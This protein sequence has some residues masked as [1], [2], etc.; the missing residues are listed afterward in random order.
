MI[1]I[2]RNKNTA[3][4]VVLMMIIAM[5]VLPLPAWLIDFLF[6]FNIILALTVLLAS[7][8]AKKPL[9]FSVFPTIL[10][11]AT[12][13]RLA[14]NVASTRIVLLEGHSGPGAAGEV[15]QSFGEVVI[16]GNYVVGLVI[17]VILMIVNFFVVT[18]GGERISEVSARFTLDAMPGKQ[19]AID[20]DLNA[21]SLNQEQAKARRQEVAREA[22]FYGSMDGAS[23]FVK[24]DA[25]A[26]LLILLINL[27]GGFAIGMT[28][29]DLPAGESFELFAVLT[30]GD[31]LVAQ[32][33]SLL[34]ATAAAIIV[35]RVNDDMEMP[36]QIKKQM[37]SSPRVIST[38]AVIM[39]ILGLIPGM[40]AV[41]FLGFAFALFFVAWRV[42]L[43]AP[44]DTTIVE[45]DKTYAEELT[46]EPLLTWSEIP[47]VDKIKIELG[48]QLVSLAES[49]QKGELP[50][51]IRG[52]RSAISKHMGVLLPEVRIRDNLRIGPTEYLIKVDGV[53]ASQGKID[54][55]K[56]LAIE[57]PD[58]YNKIEGE[59]VREPV[60]GMDAIVIEPSEKN[61]ALMQ[62]YQVVDAPTIISTHIGNVFTENLQE[63]FRHDDVIALS[64]RLKGISEKLAEALNAALTPIQQ[65]RIFRMLLVEKVSILDIENI[66]TS[67]VQTCEKSKDPFDI[68]GDIR[69][70]LCK[71]I[72]SQI[73]GDKDHINVIELGNPLQ[74]AL[75]NSYQQSAQAGFV[76]PD[77][78]PIDPNLIV[79]FEKSL[80]EAEKQVNQAGGPAVILVHRH[81]RPMIARLS[82]IYARNLY[83]LSAN[84]I[85]DGMR[86]ETLVYMS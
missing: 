55:D 71:S 7:V 2:L 32:I 11:L 1:E 34:L 30:I 72:I 68:V 31:G 13:L 62:G 3:I 36:E 23:K 50:N 85:P 21:G 78:F 42:S 16:G 80:P 58:V 51:A 27:I 82:R 63:L 43:I 29:H 77:R 35:T 67:I 79:N 69:M 5:L 22:D 56:L 76:E 44:D 26:G 24:G 57:T 12:L 64:E 9:D 20:A 74:N 38:V 47:L 10:L 49:S 60:Y 84:E 75:L 40:P 15:I 66:A 53:V 14:L 6:T 37:L 39:T 8:S 48:Y 18:K 83:V 41:P 70:S 81:L 59:L 54:P 61:D 86:V 73:N 19:M 4:P 46:A 52:R 25:I 45:A 33:P 28:Q 17:F 65:L